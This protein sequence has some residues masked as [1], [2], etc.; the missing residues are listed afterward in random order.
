MGIFPPNDEQ[1]DLFSAEPASVE[2]DCQV[3]ACNTCSL[4]APDC[5]GLSR[6]R[7]MKKLCWMLAMPEYFPKQKVKFEPTE[8]EKML[9]TVFPKGSRYKNGET[10]FKGCCNPWKRI[11]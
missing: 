11:T 9:E 5:D 7:T 6:V 4:D 10:G 2:N 3:I 8:L 1:I